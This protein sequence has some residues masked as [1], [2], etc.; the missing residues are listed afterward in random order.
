MLDAMLQAKRGDVGG[1]SL[2]VDLDVQ[3][4]FPEAV[5]TAGVEVGGFGGA[6]PQPERR[7]SPRIYFWH[8]LFRHINVSWFKIH[9]EA[10]PWMA[11][12]RKILANAARKYGAERILAMWDLFTQFPG[13]WYRGD[14]GT[15][16]YWMVRNS[17]RLMDY[18]GFIERARTHR[19]N[20]E[21]KSGLMSAADVFKCLRVR[22]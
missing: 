21:R 9:G 14:K 11:S 15:E 3:K 19:E 16:I 17:S 18:R 7:K 22:P 12:D 5:S 13:L 10:Y 1:F 4:P 2:E 6:A 20:L 8:E